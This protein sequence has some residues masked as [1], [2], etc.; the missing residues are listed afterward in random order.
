[1]STTAFLKTNRQTLILSGHKARLKSAYPPIPVNTHELLFQKKLNSRKLFFSKNYKRNKFFAGNN[2]LYNA[3]PCNKHHFFFKKNGVPNINPPQQQANDSA[4]RKHKQLL[5]ARHATGAKVLNL[6]NKNIKFFTPQ[7]LYYT[8][9]L[10]PQIPK[11]YNSG[12]SGIHYSSSPPS[13]GNSGACTY[14]G[15]LLATANLGTPIAAADT[16][17]LKKQPLIIL[18]K[19]NTDRLT[20]GAIVIREQPFNKKSI[21]NRRFKYP[22]ALGHNFIS[23]VY[24]ESLNFLK[25]FFKKKIHPA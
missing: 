6:K 1:M 16:F 13:K 12:G 23:N 10:L 24:G 4:Y 3:L 14:Y 11:H 20:V 15:N 25:N 2:N 22:P 9:N 17:F 18:K 21:R 5:L 8:N 19:L 7:Q